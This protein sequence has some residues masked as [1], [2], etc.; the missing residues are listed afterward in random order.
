MKDGCYV[1]TRTDGAAMIVQWHAGRVVEC[2]GTKASARPK[3]RTTRRL[4]DSWA[5]VLRKHE[6]ER[7]MRF[8][9]AMTGGEL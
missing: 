3:R 7:R 8:W 4:G 9:I 5:Q 2:M 6:E 1:V